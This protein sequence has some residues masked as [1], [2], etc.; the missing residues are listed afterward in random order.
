M[1]NPHYAIAASRFLSDVKNCTLSFSL[2]LL[3]SFPFFFFFPLSRALHAR[4]SHRAGFQSE[5]NPLYHD[6]PG[7]N[8][9]FFF[10]FFFYTS[11]SRIFGFNLHEVLTTSFPSNRER[12]KKTKEKER[13]RERERERKSSPRVIDGTRS[14]ARISKLRQR[15]ALSFRATRNAKSDTRGIVN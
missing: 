12:K 13:E 2:S 8:I 3:F 10:F 4:L 9:S 11:Y 6:I 1:N 7:N 5:R 15:R 14:I